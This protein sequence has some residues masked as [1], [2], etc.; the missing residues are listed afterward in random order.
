M[1]YKYCQK[2]HIVCTSG[3]FICLYVR[4]KIRITFFN[5]HQY[6]RNIKKILAK[7]CFSLRN[8]QR[9]VLVVIFLLSAWVLDIYSLAHEQRAWLILKNLWDQCITFQYVR[10]VFSTYIKDMDSLLC[11]WHT[12]DFSE[13]RIFSCT[14]IWYRR[15]CW[16]ND[17]CLS[18]SK[19]N[20]MLFFPDFLYCFPRELCIFSNIVIFR[21]VIKISRS[22]YLFKRS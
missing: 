15:K 7:L 20:S 8:F 4:V 19:A 6:H 14:S 1:H 10:G 12:Q 17:W 2:L 5:S 11:V 22:S 18:Y 3:L 16:Q 21:H 13:H 9:A